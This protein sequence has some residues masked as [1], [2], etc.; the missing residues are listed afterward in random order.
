MAIDLGVVVLDDGATPVEESLARLANQSEPPRTA[1]SASDVSASVNVATLGDVSHLLLLDSSLI[2]QPDLLWLL[3]RA[4]EAHDAVSSLAVTSSDVTK[5]RSCD[6]T[7]AAYQRLLCTARRASSLH[8]PISFAALPRELWLE[9]RGEELGQV[10]ERIRDGKVFHDRSGLLAVR[11]VDDP[12]ESFAPPIPLEPPVVEPVDG[13]WRISVVT[14]VRDRPV[15]HLR[16]SLAAWRAQSLPPA[17]VLIVDQGSASAAAE[18]YRQLASQSSPRV[19]YLRCEHPDWNKPKALNYGIRASDPRNTHVLATDCDLLFHPEALAALRSL[20]GRRRFIHGHRCDLPDLLGELRLI[21]ES[22]WNRW[23]TAAKVVDAIADPWHLMPRDWAFEV[24]GYDERMA[25][26][27]YMDIDMSARAGRALETLRVGPGSLFA[28]HYPHP[29]P[30]W[31]TEVYDSP[32]TRANRELFYDDP[33]IV[34]NPAGWGRG[35]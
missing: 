30:H 24:R 19:R 12:V 26:R 28:L 14:P 25:G 27:G 31:V 2:L 22:V 21:D 7:A 13:D 18:Q 34:R 20:A 17:E 32:Q 35:R 11:W 33:S 23:A 16:A 4:L 8:D 9:H 29:R 3:R 1:V 6:G 5:A 15:E 10:V